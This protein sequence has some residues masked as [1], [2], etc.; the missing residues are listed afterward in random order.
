MKSNTFCNDQPQDGNEYLLRVKE[1]D[2]LLLATDGIFDNLFESE[3]LSVIK[4]F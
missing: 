3:I 4:S 1:G 2:L